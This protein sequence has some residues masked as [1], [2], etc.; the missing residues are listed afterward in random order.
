MHLQLSC[1]HVSQ[2]VVHP[3]PGHEVPH[4]PSQVPCRAEQIIQ[5]PPVNAIIHRMVDLQSIST[6]DSASLLTIYKAQRY[7][8]IVKFDWLVGM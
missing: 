1:Q 7:Q 5:S 6:T 3:V 4:H 2:Q 8:R